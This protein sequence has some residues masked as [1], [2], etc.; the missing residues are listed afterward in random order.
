MRIEKRSISELVFAGYNPRKDLKSGDVEFE[1]LRRS[2][3]EYGYVD[4][5]IVNSDNTV[6]SGHQR[7]KVLREEGETEID[8]VVVDLD[9]QREKALNLAMNKISGSWDDA[10][11][12]ALLTEL[13]DSG[14][15]TGFLDDEVVKLLSQLGSD[16][17][18]D[19]TFDPVEELGNIAEPVTKPGDLYVLGRHRLLCGDSTDAKA[20]ALLAGSAKARMV[21]TD[22]P[23]NVDYGNVQHNESGRSIMN[24]NMAAEEFHAFLMHAFANMAEHTE[25]GAMVYVVMSSS[26]WGTLMGVMQAAGYHWSTTIVWVKDTLVLSRKD[27]HTRYEPMW[28][29]W[30]EGAARL[31]PLEDRTQSD[32]WEIDRP[33]RSD[34]H[35][36]MKPVA[37]V[38]RAVANSSGAGD[39]VLD[40]FGGSGTTM[41][42]CEQTGRSCLTME[43]DPKYCDVIVRRW[44]HM[45]GSQARLERRG[46]DDEP[47]ERIVD[48]GAEDR[49]AGGCGEERG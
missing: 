17:S 13:K 41:V 23:W 20:V 11:L 40:L 24:D 2:I 5:V 10:A 12:A 1:Q 29:G 45:T 38:A 46:C 35:P 28:Y 47:E 8:V 37:L 25:P 26:E 14:H 36:T 31:R 34:E 33:K 49:G 48:G 4:L 22:P 42:A 18:N 43:L 44:E 39:V 30:R 9:K 19:E 6:I 3:R 21:F 32:V 15:E 27:Y 7:L 16:V